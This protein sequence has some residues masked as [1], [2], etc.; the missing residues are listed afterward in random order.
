MRRVV[1]GADNQAPDPL[2]AALTRA[3]LADPPPDIALA[4]RVKEE[5][6]EEGETK[7]EKEKDTP[8]E[9]KPARPWDPVGDEDRFDE[10][11]IEVVDEGGHADEDDER[12]EYSYAMSFPRA[13]LTPH[14]A[15]DPLEVIRQTL[16]TRMWPNMERK[17]GRRTLPRPEVEEDGSDE[18][19]N[20]GF[21]VVFGGAG[22]EAPRPAGPASDFPPLEREVQE[23]GQGEPGYAQMLDDDDEDEDFGGFA[24]APAPSAAEYSRLDRWLDAEDD[25]LPPPTSEDVDFDD[26]LSSHP[27][28]A[29]LHAF[30]APESDEEG[31]RFEDDFAARGAPAAIPLDPTPLLL[32][33]QQVRAEL[34]QVEDEDERR[35]RAAREVTRLM[36]SLGLG[37]AAFDFD[38]DEDDED[39]GEI[40]DIRP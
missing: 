40:A 24:S 22:A 19:G 39:L 3:A 2:P 23:G 1:T 30:Q 5:E 26:D 33:L 32:H 17:A 18:E 37:G 8:A 6:E 15:L 9:A 28:V 12:R 11:G 34:G 4:V 13:Q 10:L 25:D 27:G 29:R 31:E 14:A 36:Q 21:P 7:D 38:E 35:T 20:A 16:M